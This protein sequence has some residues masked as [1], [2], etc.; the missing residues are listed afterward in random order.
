[1][2][3][4]TLASALALFLALGQTYKVELY[5]GEQCRGAPLGSIKPPN[6]FYTYCSN[7]KTEAQSA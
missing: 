5:K 4:T 1:M 7:T 6:Y 3:S 2:R